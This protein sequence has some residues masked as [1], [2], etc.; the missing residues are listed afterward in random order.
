MLSH[1]RQITIAL[2]SPADAAWMDHPDCVAA[3][4]NWL[5][6]TPHARLRIVTPQPRDL[7][8]V[9]PRTWNALTWFSHQVQA[10]VPVRERTAELDGVVFEGHAVIY[11]RRDAMEW[12]H[13]ALARN[14]VAMAMAEKL[15]ARVESASEQSL[16]T[17]GLAG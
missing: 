14:A 12:H 6:N 7:I 11:R 4:R 10:L 16:G 5:K 8:N 15:L 2:E 1:V 9:W 17:T 13:L 3:L